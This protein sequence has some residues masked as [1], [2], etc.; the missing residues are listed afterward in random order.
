MSATV[1]CA[2]HFLQGKDVAVLGN[3]D[4]ALH[5]A[6]ELAP[7]ADSVTIYTDGK[8]PEFS[9]KSSFAVNTMKIQSVE[10]DEKVSD[11]V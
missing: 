7:M 9:R 10:G 2:M 5:E 11:C 3:S 6:E 1:L 4:F 8:E